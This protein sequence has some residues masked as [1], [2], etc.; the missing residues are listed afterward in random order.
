MGLEG[1]KA[2][3]SMSK[4]YDIFMRKNLTMYEGIVN[5]VILRVSQEDRILEI[6]TATG[7]ISL[8]LSADLKHV[9][10][11]D[12][13]EK[14]I[15]RARKKARKQQINNVTFRMGDAY[16]L[17]YKDGGMDHI[18]MAN[19]LHIMPTPEK[20]LEEVKRVLKGD[21]LFFAP[22]IVHKGSTYAGIFSKIASIVG[23]KVYSKWN[24]QDYREFLENHGFRVVTSKK[25]DASFPV[26]YYVCRKA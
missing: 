9:E 3:N 10:A 16:K 11:I 19:V 20:A 12:Y 8:M 22:T 7:I 1:T 23:F 17:A 21:G 18:I 4:F 14:M 26:A 15:L 6:G 24:Q 5:D 25:I 13:S 2:W